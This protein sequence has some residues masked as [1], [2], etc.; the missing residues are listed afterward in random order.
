MADSLQS[1][2]VEPIFVAQRQLTALAEYLPREYARNIAVSIVQR[3]CIIA[4]Q[5]DR[6][7]ENA[8]SHDSSWEASPQWHASNLTLT[9]RV[10]FDTLQLLRRFCFPVMPANRILTPLDLGVSGGDPF[11]VTIYSGAG[12]PRLGV[13]NKKFLCW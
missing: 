6:T 5:S 10:E 9:V 3:A 13:E 7:R 1:R 4:V 11:G 8:D 12:F 2:R